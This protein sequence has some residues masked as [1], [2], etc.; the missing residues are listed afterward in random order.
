[1]SMRSSQYPPAVKSLLIANG[2][3]FLLTSQPEYGRLILEYFALW[4][5]T[6]FIPWQLVTYG[7]IHGG[8]AH[9]FFNMFALWMFGS[10]I[11]LAW[12]TRRFLIFYLA[13]VLGAAVTQLV[14][15]TLSGQLY[16][17]VGASGGVFGLLLAFGMMY[18]NRQLLLLFPPIPIKAKYFVAGYGMIEL[19]LGVFGLEEGVAHFAHLGGMLVGFLLIQYWRHHWPFGPRRP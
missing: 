9:L 6:R 11:E 12:G 19:S 13:C 14:V 10:Q 1:M 5:G 15:A 2:I 7:F 4:P 17:T 16:P 8:F 18:P 3:V